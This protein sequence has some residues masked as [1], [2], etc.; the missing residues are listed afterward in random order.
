MS[1]SIKIYRSDQRDAAIA[2]CGWNFNRDKEGT[3]VSFVELISGKGEYTR[4]AFIATIHLRI[5]YAIEILGKGADNVRRIEIYRFFMINN[6][7]I[8]F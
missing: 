6:S 1:G 3:F 8:T 2:L 5:R 7:V 4:A